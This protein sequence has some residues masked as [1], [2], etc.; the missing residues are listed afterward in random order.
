MY[1]TTTNNN[2]EKAFH[3]WQ[4]NNNTE[5]RTQ[6]SHKLASL[7]LLAERKFGLQEAPL[8]RLFRVASGDEPGHA[9]GKGYPV[10]ESFYL[11]KKK[12]QNL[13]VV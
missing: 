8:R 4:L 1:F 6:R 13:K 5:L 3:W 2:S 10:Q 9:W 7:S 11:D 12:N